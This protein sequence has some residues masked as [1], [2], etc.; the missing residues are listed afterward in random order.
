MAPARISTGIA[1]LDRLLHGGYIKGRSYLLTGESGTGKTTACL[2][3]LVSA[4]LMGEK[5]VYVTVD[6]RPAEILETAESFAWDL[7][8]YI[9]DKTLV[10]LDASPY[11]GGRAGAG[12]EKGVDPQKIVADLGNYAR[13]L[14]ATTLIVDPVTPLILPSDPHTAAHDQARSLIQLIQAQLNTTTIFTAHCNEG[15]TA[16]ST[17][18]IEQFLVSGVLIFK[19]V[20]IDG[21]HER[22]MTIKKMRG[23]ATDPADYRFAIRRGSG[24]VLLDSADA[25]TGEPCAELPVFEFFNPAKKD[26]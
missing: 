12:G 21:R 14:D 17:A 11:F 7:Q 19:T 2:Q 6:E 23:I 10:I 3:F 22:T 5:A 20:A 25:E 26:F 16:S 15:T 1:G 9:Q 4:L 18:G 8:H 24:I 13:R